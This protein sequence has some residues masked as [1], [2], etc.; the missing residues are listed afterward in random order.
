MVLSEGEKRIVEE[1][2]KADGESAQ[3]VTEATGLSH[4]SV[5]RSL[6]KLVDIGVVEAA[7]T[8]N[9]RVYRL[10]EAVTGKREV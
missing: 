4:R 5:Q 3:L 9:D 2:C 6:K 8:T 10:S 7:G 1:L